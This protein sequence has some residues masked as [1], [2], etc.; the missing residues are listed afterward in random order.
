MWVNSSILLMLRKSIFLLFRASW[1]WNF[2]SWKWHESILIIQVTIW[3][4][5][6]NFHVELNIYK[7]IFYIYPINVNTKALY[8]KKLVNFAFKWTVLLSWPHS[9]GDC[10]LQSNPYKRFQISIRS[11]QPA[12]RSHRSVGYLYYINCISQSL[13]QID[14]KQALNLRERV[15]DWW[16]QYHF[17]ALHRQVG[18]PSILW[19]VSQIL[20]SIV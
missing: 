12:T 18:N 2:Y 10:K 20:K 8:Y 4:F 1:M 7:P 16:K 15:A 19:S 11:P 6:N 14:N 17:Q 9:A 3:L 13:V 5:N